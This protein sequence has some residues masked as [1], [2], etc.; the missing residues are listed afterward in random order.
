MLGHDAEHR[1]AEHL[2]LLLAPVRPQADDDEHE[3][4]AGLAVR[5]TIDVAPLRAGAQAA[6]LHDAGGR[7]RR[8]Y[9]FHELRD[10]ELRLEVSRVFD[11]DMGQSDPPL[12]WR[13]LASEGKYRIEPR[14]AAQSRNG[15]PRMP[16]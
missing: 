8:V 13:R 15:F 2:A 11:G 14:R 16:M 3:G 4:V 1:F 5:H 9:F 7:R 12:V 6:K 10:L